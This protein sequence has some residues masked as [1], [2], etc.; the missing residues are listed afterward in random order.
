MP[1]TVI[2][3]RCAGVER[4]VHEVLVGASMELVRSR[5]HGQIKEAA[6]GL[7]KLGRIIARLDREFLYRIDTALGLRLYGVPAVG[8]IL[9]IDPHRLG[10]RGHSVNSDVDI[11]VISSAGKKLDHRVRI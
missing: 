5:S 10:I 3:E 4:L 8:G 1:V 7:P 11:R 2:G 9:S 6:A